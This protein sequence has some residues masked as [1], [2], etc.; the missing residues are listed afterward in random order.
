MLED[1]RLL[2]CSAGDPSRPHASRLPGD[3]LSL[4][5]TQKL[6]LADVD[7]LAVCLGPGAFTGLRVGIAAMQGLAFANG[8]SIL[9]V[10]A[11]DA[12]AMAAG[13]DGTPGG[14]GVWIDAT[15]KEV[16]AARYERAA[17]ALGIEVSDPAVAAPPQTVLERWRMRGTTVERWI[18]DG[19]LAYLDL[20][21]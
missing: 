18:G 10:S 19:A 4:L 2:G 21:R 1:G 12:L 5:D 15:R 11:L 6:R 16:F 14:I 7:L 13:R 3:L 9:G 8:R 20:I 17:T